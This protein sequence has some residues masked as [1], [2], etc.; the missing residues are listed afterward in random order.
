MNAPIVV[1]HRR[2]PDRVVGGGGDGAF[3]SPM[4]WANVHN[5]IYISVRYVNC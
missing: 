4:V 2:L 3:W 1:H 5:D